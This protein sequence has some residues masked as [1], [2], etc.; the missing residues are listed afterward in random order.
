MDV[1]AERGLLKGNVL[2]FGC[3]RGDDARIL[4]WEREFWRGVLAVNPVYQHSPPSRPMVDGLTGDVDA[5][6]LHY[7]PDGITRRK[8][9]TITCHYVLNVVDEHERMA[10][11]NQIRLLLKKGGTAYVTV[12]RDLTA[13]YTTPKGTQQYLVF[14]PAHVEVE[15]RG[16]FIIYRLTN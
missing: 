10:I 12:R 9:Q 2:D 13:D 4:N 15:S 8:Y 1:L 11:L 14:L 6:D 3:G 5:Y 16:K 7:A